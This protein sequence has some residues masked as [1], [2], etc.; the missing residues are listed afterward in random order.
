M[1]DPRGVGIDITSWDSYM[2]TTLDYYMTSVLEKTHFGRHKFTWTLDRVG[3]ALWHLI[4]DPFWFHRILWF[5]TENWMFQ[6]D[7]DDIDNSDVIHW[8]LVLERA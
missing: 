7:P 3:Y 5:L 2:D 8:W 4:A 1:A 6:F